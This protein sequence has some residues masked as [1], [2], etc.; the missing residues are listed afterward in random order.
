MQR[1]PGQGEGIGKSGH[2]IA[3][4]RF[5][6]TALTRARYARLPSPWSEAVDF[7]DLRARA[8]KK[9][10]H[11]RARLLRKTEKIDSLWSGRGIWKWSRVI[12]QN[13][14]LPARAQN[15]EHFR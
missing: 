2:G 9:V 8:S 6:G 7:L 15:C 11:W 13:D 10:E 3:D 5:V 1:S 12:F 14:P 4:P